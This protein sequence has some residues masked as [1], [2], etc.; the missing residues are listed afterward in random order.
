MNAQASILLAATLII[1]AVGSY[2]ILRTIFR[3]RR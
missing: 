3:K 2:G 1:T